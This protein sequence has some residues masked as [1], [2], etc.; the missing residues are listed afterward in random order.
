MEK[1]E[2]T[3]QTN[4]TNNVNGSDEL[5]SGNQILKH[6]SMIPP[7]DLVDTF[8]ITVPQGREINKLYVSLSGEFANTIEMTTNI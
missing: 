6:D 2:T 1:T 4:P 5:V 3:I 7:G 8:T